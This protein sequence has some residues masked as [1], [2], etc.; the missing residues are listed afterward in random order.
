M[1]TLEEYKE[2]LLSYYRYNIDSL[3]E[4]RKEREFLLSKFYKDDLLNKIIND[5]YSFVEDIFNCDTLEYNY[6]SFDLDDDTSFGI[7]L[8]ISGGGYSD[9]LYEDNNGKIISSH[10]LHQIFGNNLMIEVKCDE[11]ERECEEDVLSYDCYYSLYLQDFPKDLDKI[12]EK[13]LNNEHNKELT[14]RIINK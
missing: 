12:K 13:Y 9:Y 14:K 11:V 4:K 7:S 2:Y 10:I 6:C 8:N 5:S 1:I 3:P